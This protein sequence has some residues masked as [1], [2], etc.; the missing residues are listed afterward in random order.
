MSSLVVMMSGDD[1]GRKG[2]LARGKSSYDSEWIGETWTKTA[3]MEIATRGTMWVQLH[4]ST[5]GPE[6]P[7]LLPT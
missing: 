6:S 7:C 3:Q 1:Y 4:F 5:A 2:S